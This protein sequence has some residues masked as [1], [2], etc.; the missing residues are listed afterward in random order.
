MKKVG[1]N[2][3]S[4]D[5]VFVENTAVVTGPKEKNGPYGNYFDYSY[6]NN[7]CNEKTWEKAEIALVKK[8]F[9]IICQK[10]KLCPNDID[11]MFSGDLN[12]QIVAST[13]AM[14]NTFIPFLGTF[15]AC[16]TITENMILGSI[17]VD[18]IK[19]AKVLVAS[20]SHNATSERQ[21]RYPTE[22][23]GQKPTS[24]TFTTTAAG[25]CLLGSTPTRICVKSGTIGKIID[26]NQKDAQDMG[27]IMAPSA[28]ETLFDHLSN[29]NETVDDYDV[30]V[31]GDL[32]IYGSE[33]FIKCCKENGILLKDKH[34]DAGKNLYNIKKQKVFAG[35]SGCGCITAYLLS[36]IVEELKKG[37]YKKVLILATGALLNPVMVAQKDTIPCISHAICL[38]RWD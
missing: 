15:A 27:R 19:N 8:A 20:S 23:G 32:S 36:Y 7:Y 28:A 21:F 17:Y 14:R 4:F 3:L 12:N 2:S 1:R 5:S 6:D 29:F 22:Y 35:G 24:M 16:S 33:L 38:E 34:K 18:S 13:Y 25:I 10:E 11:V 31:T 37:T 9:E 26:V 30:I